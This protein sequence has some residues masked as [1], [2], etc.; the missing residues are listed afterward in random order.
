MKVVVA[1]DDSKYSQA[2]VDAIIARPWWGDTE[3]L[4]MTVVQ[5]GAMAYS[6]AAYYP[7]QWVSIREAEVASARQLLE[8]TREKLMAAMPS[9]KVECA[10]EEGSPSA[11][12]A[13]KAKDWQADLI[14]VGSHGRKGLNKFLL[15]SV[16][17]AVLNAAPCSVEIIKMAPAQSSN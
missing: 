2:A 9:T 10:L 17:E 5:V 3:F 8:K 13:A 15:G 12:I 7:E 16:A 4:I 14:I 11:E 6:G 1:V